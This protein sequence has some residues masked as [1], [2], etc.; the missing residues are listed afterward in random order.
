MGIGQL[1]AANYWRFRRSW[2][3]AN[4]DTSYER[5]PRIR[6]LPG[7]PPYYLIVLPYACN[8]AKKSSCPYTHP[9]SGTEERS[10]LRKTFFGSTWVMMEC[11]WKENHQSFVE[12]CQVSV[13]HSMF[14]FFNNAHWLRSS[15]FS[16]WRSVKLHQTN[17][18]I[19][20]LCCSLLNVPFAFFLVAQQQQQQKKSCENHTLRE[21]RSWCH[22]FLSFRLCC[23]HNLV[24]FM[25]KSKVKRTIICF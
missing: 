6:H 11:S 2:L 7:I 10:Q 20:C 12:M 25:W 9:H 15:F 3:F 22:I 5:F 18:F 17:R 16:Y 21:T 14:A 24:R 23:R 19:R 4:S 8:T 1:V 13:L